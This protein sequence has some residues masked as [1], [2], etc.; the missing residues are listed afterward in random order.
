MVDRGQ[1]SVKEKIFNELK[2]LF[3][4]SCDITIKD[5]EDK[6]SIKER[7]AKSYI[8]LLREYGF[9]IK[10]K[11]GKYNLINKSSAGG[12]IIGKEDVRKAKII[13]IVSENNNMLTK[14][15]I[16]EKMMHINSE[17]VGTKTFERAIQ[18]CEDEGLIYTFNGKYIISANVITLSKVH[19]LTLYKFMQSFYKY[20]RPIICEEI[21][22]KIRSKIVDEVE[23]NQY[24]NKNGP[25]INSP[26]KVKI[27]FYKHINEFEKLNKTSKKAKLCKMDGYYIYEDEIHLLDY[28]SDFLQRYGADCEVLEP[29]ELKEIMKEKYSN[30]LAGYG[31]DVDGK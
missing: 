31:V 17:T 15:E 21:I 24:E 28:F 29:A 14:K 16:I 23:N 30:I 9:D 26:Y 25:Y 10:C 3:V 27:K 13:S 20:D 19:V 4:T 6:F 18:S 22:D 1:M 8:K 12:K 5:I 7:S 11:N 2:D